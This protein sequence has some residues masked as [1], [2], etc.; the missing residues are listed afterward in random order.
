MIDMTDHQFKFLML[1]L[2]GRIIDRLESSQT[3][4]EAKAKILEAFE[5]VEK[6]GLR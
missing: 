6:E 4:D 2:K 5:E 3:V 1:T